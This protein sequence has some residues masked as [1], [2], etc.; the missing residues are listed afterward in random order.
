MSDTEQLVLIDGSGYIFRAF[1]ALPPM[2]RGD[3]TVNAVYGFTGMVM[4]LV[5]DLSP[6]HVAVVF[7]S[8]RKTFRNDTMPR[9]GEPHRSARRAG[10]AVRLCAR[11]QQ[12]SACRSSRFRVSRL[13]I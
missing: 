12:R 7:D 11:Q 5:D 3:G 2:T 4:K 8:S 1:H 9:E 13:T 6:A 10:A